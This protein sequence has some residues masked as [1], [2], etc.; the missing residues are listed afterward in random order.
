[1]THR[2]RHSLHLYLLLGFF[3]LSAT[4]GRAQ[5]LRFEHL[6]TED[7]LSNPTVTDIVQDQQGYLWVATNLGLNRYDG[8]AVKRYLPDPDDST[9]IPN[10][11][12]M[13]LLVDRQGRLWIGSVW[14]NEEGGVYRLDPG[15][16]QFVRYPEFEN[17]LLEDRDGLLWFAGNPA[18]GGLAR[19]DPAREA[20][21]WYTYDP[22]DPHSLSGKRVMAMCQDRQ[23]TRWV[24][25][26]GGGLNRFDPETETF[27]RYQHDPDDE[28]TLISNQV[29]VLFE[30]ARGTFWVG[31]SGDGLH[32]M[33][34][35]A[36]T[37][38]RHT[39]DP[40]D[41]NRLSRPYLRADPHRGFLADI[42]EDRRGVLWFGAV[43]GGLLRYDPSSGAVTRYEQDQDNPS[44]LWNNEVSSI[45]ETHEGTLWIGTWGAG[46]HRLEAP[47]QGVSRDPF[48]T[49]D[50]EGDAA[51]VWAVVEAR[52]GTQWWGTG[53]GLM[54][55]AGITGAVTRYRHNPQ[56][57]SSLSADWIT[58][59]HEDGEGGLWVG[60][61]GGG[62]NRFDPETETFTRY[63]HV[64]EEEQSLTDDYVR[65]VF[66]DRE[67]RLW[68]VTWGGGLHRFDAASGT[69]ERIF[70]PQ[71]YDRSVYALLDQLD[72]EGRSLAALL[73]I[74][75]FENRHQTF[76]LR[77]ETPVL[78]AH[79]AVL[80]RADWLVDQGTIRKEGGEL[81]YHAMPTNTVYGGG[82]LRNRVEIAIDTL[83]PGRYELIYK[84][85]EGGY[86]YEQWNGAPPDH[87]ERWGIQVYSLQDRALPEIQTVA[88]RSPAR[89]LTG[90]LFVTSI[91]EDAQ[92]TLWVGT[93]AG[94]HRLDRETGTFVLD[95]DKPHV[96]VPFYQVRVDRQ[97]IWWI[98]TAQRATGG[99]RL[100]RF[101]PASGSRTAITTGIGLPSA[102]ISDL[103][104]DEAGRLW[105]SS[106]TGLGVVEA[107]SQALRPFDTGTGSSAQAWTPRFEGASRSRTG[108]LY[109]GQ[110]D[111]V[112]VIDPAR[113]FDPTPPR[114][115]LTGV[116]VFEDPVQAGLGSAHGQP[117]P[118]RLAHDRNEVTFEYVGIYFRK[119]AETRYA[120]RLEGY[121][122]QWREA[123]TRRSATYT[124]LPP[125]DYTFRVKAASA[126]GVWNEEGASLDITI[127]PPWWR[128]W[129]AYGLYG[130]VF[131]AGVFAIGR[132]QRR[133]L[134]ARERE[135]ARERELEQ[136]HEIEQAYHQ[137]EEAHG[138]LKAAQQ[139][140]VQ[141]EK[142][143]SLGTLT[144]GIAHEIKNPLNF[145]NNFAELNEE[146]AD[147]M[148]EAVEAG[149]RL[150]HLKTLIA[151]LRE[152]AQ[153]IVKQ[154]R[155]AD[156][157]VKSM[158]A[159]ASGGTGEREAT[160]VN[161]LVEEYVELA[162]HGRRAHSPGFFV[163]V[164]RDYDEAVGRVVMVPQEIGRVLLNL[165]SNAFDAVQ[166]KALALDGQ[167]VPQVS[168]VTRREGDRVQI[169]V[170]DNGPGIAAEMV[171]KVFEPFF[172]TKGPGRGTGLG[173]SLSYDIVTQGHGGAL[174]VESSEGEG[175][176][177]IITL[178]ADSSR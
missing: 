12:L 146:L 168:V 59:L 87:P 77:E 28:R 160:D 132:I 155:R 3:W 159:H 7:G 114:V 88:P 55:R 81:V 139:Q 117:A 123:G 32:T 63:R 27:T 44:G 137:L 128:T 89:G 142:M 42:Q 105:V 56:N 98:G 69:V 17:V 39:I 124:N 76:E 121:D 51:G 136:A 40:N 122:E 62:L 20:V 93:D 30:D 1:M 135:K 57:S 131:V 52:D 99:N 172:T 126:D 127:L 2:R 72:A 95:T 113:G 129:W 154:G 161:A 33:D 144:A 75:P 107:G 18:R 41:P 96:D 25:T 4:A 38:T 82:W 31:T 80:R 10:R 68:V 94:F 6:T 120:Y 54:R 176:T 133:R 134:I 47:S 58:A 45:Y 37:F 53:E 21:T 141:Q 23:G 97:G 158:M 151:D 71:T 175:A 163:D 169:W 104:E 119:A 74:R 112:T 70:A 65:H 92:G 61:L 35:R 64:P 140:L 11:F 162:W 173:L 9:S 115:V 165:L 177:F 13:N 174:A 24:G 26:Y 29:F 86:G 19:M 102:G 5:D 60:T 150:V 16:G 84:S 138:R 50:S 49:S 15:S 108:R 167:Y 116:R 103:L 8:Y 34:R 43:E 152:N 149:E 109:F 100:I 178:P 36:G 83:A 130:L 156:G 101:D 171:E 148:E 157:I 110:R 48:T 147:E 91:H 111:G 66:E 22:A 125:G 118:L 46:L 85:G 78:I 90:D 166:E 153:V 143:A 170:S 73:K 164:E 67:G 79:Q 106:F 14:T 145:I